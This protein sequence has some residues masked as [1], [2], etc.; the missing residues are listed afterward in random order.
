M[1]LLN[2]VYSRDTG[3]SQGENHERAT[4]DPKRELGTGTD[5]DGPRYP[6]V[7]AVVYDADILE[8]FYDTSAVECSLDDDEI[9]S[10]EAGFMHGYLGRWKGF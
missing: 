4:T 5:D 2:A 7:L 1:G 8:E 9:D 3:E 6:E 10:A